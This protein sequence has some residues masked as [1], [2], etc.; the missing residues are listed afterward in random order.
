LY[1]ANDLDLVHAQRDV[2]RFDLFQPAFI[3]DSD[4]LAGAVIAGYG[5]DPRTG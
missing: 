2:G 1:G 4:T 5:G 3:F